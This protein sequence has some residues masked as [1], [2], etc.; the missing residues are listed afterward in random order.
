MTFQTEF[1][2]MPAADMPAIPA[3]FEDT[4]WH[5]D[6]CPSYSNAHYQIF[7]DYVDP[8]ERE[9]SCNPRFIIVPMQH[10]VEITADSLGTDDWN[11]VL[12]FLAER[13]RVLD[14]LATAGGACLYWQLPN[15]DV[16]L[17]MVKCNILRVAGDLVIH[18]DAT[19]V[20]YGETY[21]MPEA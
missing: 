20:E 3:G 5:N 2:D 15:P 6:T 4:S 19:V 12:A 16:A 13:T 11:A 18:P 17:D 1:P 8:A 7:I 14:I 9:M 10:G 21:R